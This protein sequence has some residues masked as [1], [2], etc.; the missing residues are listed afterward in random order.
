MSLGEPKW[1]SMHLDAW[2]PPLSDELEVPPAH[3]L[4]L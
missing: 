1:S 2:G 4:K 3:P